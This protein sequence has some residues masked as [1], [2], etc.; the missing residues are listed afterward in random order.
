MSVKDHTLFVWSK[1]N[2]IKIT[3]STVNQTMVKREENGLWYG[4]V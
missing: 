2:P 1:Y 3:D 4:W